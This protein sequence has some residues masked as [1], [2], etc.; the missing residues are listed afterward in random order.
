MYFR[1]CLCFGSHQSL[2]FVNPIAENLDFHEKSMDFWAKNDHF[3]NFD[4]MSGND[5]IRLLYSSK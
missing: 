1:A 2:L 5:R 3:S 4:K